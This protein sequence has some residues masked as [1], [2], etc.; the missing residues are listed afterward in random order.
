[1]MISKSRASAMLVA[2]LDRIELVPR[3]QLYTVAVEQMPFIS[4]ILATKVL[5][6]VVRLM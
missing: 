4:A 1:M 2:Q 5:V 6:Q 3:S